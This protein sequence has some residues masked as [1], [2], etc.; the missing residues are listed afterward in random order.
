MFNHSL[1]IQATCKPTVLGPYCGSSP[2]NTETA[3]YIAVVLGATG[4]LLLAAC[5]NLAV[6]K[7]RSVCAERGLFG[8]NH[9]TATENMDLLENRA[10]FQQV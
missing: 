8:S 4:L 1:L 2:S 7:C 9:A 10:G 5:C 3:T 6:K